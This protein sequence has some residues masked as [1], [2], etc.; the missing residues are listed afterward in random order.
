[1][2]KNAPMFKRIS[3]QAKKGKTRTVIPKEKGR[4]VPAKGKFVKKKHP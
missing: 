2:L 3:A 4:G 1:M